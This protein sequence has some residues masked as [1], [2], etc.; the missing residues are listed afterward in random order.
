MKSPDSQP[1]Q[2]SAILSWLSSGRQLTPAE[3]LQQFGCMRLGARVHE[4]R[5]AGHAI[6]R[7][8]V[9]VGITPRGQTVRVASYSLQP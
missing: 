2:N 3:A 5:R 4:L 9:P 7:E 1:T 6:R 8:L